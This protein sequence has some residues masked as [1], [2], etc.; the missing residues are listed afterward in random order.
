[1]VYPIPTYVCFKLVWVQMFW[2]FRLTF[3]RFTSHWYLQKYTRCFNQSS[4]RYFADNCYIIDFIVHVPSHFHQPIL[5]CSCFI[6]FPSVHTS[7]IIFDFHFLQ[8]TV[9]L[10]HFTY[11]SS[12]RS[13]LPYLAVFILHAWSFNLIVSFTF[14][15]MSSLEINDLQVSLDKFLIL[16]RHSLLETELRWSYYYLS[17]YIKQEIQP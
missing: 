13:C 7:F 11:H 12:S 8:S 4:C 10:I 1:M 17:L 6:S 3:L 5:Q 2:V 15:P 14:Q 9:H 16:D